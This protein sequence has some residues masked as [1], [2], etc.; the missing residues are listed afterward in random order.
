LTKLKTDY[1]ASVDLNKLK[2]D[3]DENIE[4]L[5]NANIVIQENTKNI[6]STNDL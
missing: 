4:G 2:S 3:L 5:R 6:N 1:A